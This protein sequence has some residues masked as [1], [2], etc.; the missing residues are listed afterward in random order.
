[1]RSSARTRWDSPVVHRRSGT[2]TR[3]DARLREHW[4]PQAGGPG[5]R[6]RLKHARFSPFDRARLLPRKSGDASRLLLTT[7]RL[8]FGNPQEALE[9]NQSASSRPL[10]AQ[11]S[12]N[13]SSKSEAVACDRHRETASISC[14]ILLDMFYDALRGRVQ[15]ARG[16]PAA[17]AALPHIKGTSAI[18]TPPIRVGARVEQ[19]PSSNAENRH[20]TYGA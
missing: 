15:P 13:V 3:C 18:M 17:R 7:S 14:S 9:S 19:A 10:L 1:M 12:T 5:K 8:L 11:P 16:I 20:D 2:P 6:A 4:S